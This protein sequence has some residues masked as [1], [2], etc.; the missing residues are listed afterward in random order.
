MKKAPL[1]TKPFDSSLPLVLCHMDLSPSNVILD[2]HNSVWLIDWGR[3]GFYPKFFEFA[4]MKRGWSRYQLGAWFSRMVGG[5]YNR[6]MNFFAA[7]SW[8]LDVGF[9]M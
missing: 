8:A 9:L 4:G 1:S 3:S 2:D 7:I 5:F 6:Q